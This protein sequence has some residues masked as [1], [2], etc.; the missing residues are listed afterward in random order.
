MRGIPSR[1][2]SDQTASRL[3]EM[4]LER[5]MQPGDRFPSERELIESFGVGRSTIR[6]AVK[7]L[8][9]E[10]LV[11]IRRGTGTYISHLPG[12]SKDPLGLQFAPQQN[13]LQNLFEARVLIE[14]QIA[15]LAAQRA[16]PEDIVRLSGILQQFL[17]CGDPALHTQLDIQFHTALAQ[18]TGNAVLHRFL[19]VICEGIYEGR[20]K[21][22]TV[23]GSWERAKEWHVKIFHSVQGGDAEGARKETYG[24]L[25]QTAQEANIIINLGGQEYA[26]NFTP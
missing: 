18:C 25:M 2:L 16:T 23:P 19:P 17:A 22:A 20:S 24:H 1:E 15:Y 11:E 6:E 10:N 12:V 7:L 21:T 5:Q 4:I 14:P 13:L 8:V 9:A 26:K 3:R